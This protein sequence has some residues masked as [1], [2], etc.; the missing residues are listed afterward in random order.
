[1]QD[2]EN[3]KIFVN[4]LSGSGRHPALHCLHQHV[5]SFEL[6]CNCRCQTSNSSFKRSVE[7]FEKRACSNND[8]NGL[9][10]RE[11]S[12]AADTGSGEIN[13]ALM[14]LRVLRPIDPLSV[15]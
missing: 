14:T 11:Q 1:M 6:N 12:T 7:Q 13:R 9:W 8:Q 2:R 10:T 15:S 3:L 5:C 4:P